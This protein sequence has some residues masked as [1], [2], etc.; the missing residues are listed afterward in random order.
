[1]AR[2]GRGGLG[3]GDRLILLL[4]W[5]TTCGLVYLLGFYVGKGTQAR[6][7][8][9]EQQV[10]RL[11]VTSARPRRG[12]C[13][14][15][16]APRRELAPRGARGG[17]LHGARQPHPQ[18]RGGR[19]PRETA[20]RPRLRRHAGTRGAR[21][22]HL[23]PRAGRPLHHRRAGRGDD[24]PP[25]RARGRR[26]RLRSLGMK[27][28]ARTEAGGART[29]R[30][31]ATWP[32]RGDLATLAREGNLIPVCRE[33][34]A[35]LETPVSAFLKIHRGPYGFLLESVEGGEK[36]G[37]YSFPGTEPARVL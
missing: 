35:D 14:P 1:M 7:L 17:R 11:P 18:P 32:A 8:R 19:R 13:A 15:R 26:A 16:A 29:L 28:A 21:R 36:W 20:P 9:V 23:V 33:I 25:A 31:G 30:A 4:A 2:D 27:R 3:L 6:S 34:L 24:A 22:R 10:V 12:A 5:I 37:R